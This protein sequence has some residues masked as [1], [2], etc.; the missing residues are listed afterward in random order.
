[1]VQKFNLYYPPA[2]QDITSRVDAITKLTGKFRSLH[3]CSSFGY[4]KM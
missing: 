2:G 4:K 3:G 1:M